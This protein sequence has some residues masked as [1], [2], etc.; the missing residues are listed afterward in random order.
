MPKIHV[1]GMNA[2]TNGV[3]SPRAALLPKRLFG[4]IAALIVM[5]G[6]GIGVWVFYASAGDQE[7]RALLERRAQALR[8]KNLA[9]YVSCFSPQYQSGERTYRQLQAEAAQWFA[10]FATIQFVFQIRAIET[11]GD[12]AYVDNGYTFSVAGETGEP[13]VIENRELLELRRE[14]QTWTILTSHAL[15]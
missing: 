1:Y 9:L 10:N 7:I 11:H 5:I 8:E 15:Q 4:V 6:G 12:T 13:I 2:T 14:Q 3:K